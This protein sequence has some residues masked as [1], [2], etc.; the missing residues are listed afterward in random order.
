MQSWR[1]NN[2]QTKELMSDKIFQSSLGHNFPRVKSYERDSRQEDIEGSK[3]S[4][5]PRLDWAI[6]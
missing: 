1:R 6:K 3:F 5:P 2:D 4:N